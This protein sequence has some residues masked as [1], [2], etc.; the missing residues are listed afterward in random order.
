MEPGELR[1]YPDGRNSVGVVAQRGGARGTAVREGD[2][3]SRGGRR[4]ARGTAGQ[5]RPRRAM[6][7]R[8]RFS[9]IG[10]DVRMPLANRLTRSSCNDHHTS[11]TSGSS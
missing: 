4:F 3:G 10:P 11:R 9:E 1:H 5:L 7:L 8:I 6:A 2:G